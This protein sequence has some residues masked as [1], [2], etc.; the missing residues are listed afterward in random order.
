[1][2]SK[3]PTAKQKL[4]VTTYIAE[5]NGAKAAEGAGY[6][7]RSAKV[8]ASRLL[9]NVNLRE[10]IDQGIEAKNDE[11]RH[12]ACLLRIVKVKEAKGY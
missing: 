6:A 3:S 2:A 12:A 1:M 10:Y 7:K 5:P 11:V 9:T 4:F 8:T